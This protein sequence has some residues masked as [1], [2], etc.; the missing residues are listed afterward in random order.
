MSR[1]PV[2]L[3]WE[4]WVWVENGGGILGRGILGGVMG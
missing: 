4:E 2:M 1:V 3:W